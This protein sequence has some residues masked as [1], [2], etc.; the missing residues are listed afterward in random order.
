MRQAGEIEIRS[1]PAIESLRPYLVTKTV[2]WDLDIPDVFRAAQFI[3]E[4]KQFEARGEFPNLTLICL[5]NDHTSGTKAES[6]TPAAQVADNDL[7]FGQIVEALSRSRFWPETCIF[8]IED[9][10]QSGWDHVSGFRPTAYV[11][12]RMQELEQS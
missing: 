1:R 3:G 12:S 2:G 9:H 5:P 4:L 8:V 11:A 10:P 7:A 6:P